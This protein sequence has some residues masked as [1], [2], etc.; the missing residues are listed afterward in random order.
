MFLTA[1]TRYFKIFSY[2]EHKKIN[3]VVVCSS[4]VVISTKIQAC[5][6]GQT[7]QLYELV[8]Y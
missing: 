2:F 1:E 4:F 5:R 3:V 6:P 8:V 7:P